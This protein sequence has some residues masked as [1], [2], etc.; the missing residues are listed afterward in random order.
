MFDSHSHYSLADSRVLSPAQIISRYD[1]YN[2]IGAV[3]SSTP[4]SKAELLYQHAPKRIIPFLSLYKTKANKP[5]WMLDLNTLNDIEA[6][7]DAFPYQGIGEF[8]IFK[9]DTYSPVLKRIIQI[10]DERSL[11]LQIHGDAE[12]VDRI[13]EISPNVQ[14]IW[15]HLGT[16]PTPDFLASLLKRHPQNLYIDTSVRDG[17]FFDDRGRLN[18]EWES[19]F[20]Q[21][22][23]RLLAA[24]DTYSTLR[25]LTVGHTLSKMRRWL[26]QLPPDVAH[27]IAYQNALKL[28]DRPDLTP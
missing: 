19:F 25:W 5:N 21:H 27:K 24:V 11:M 23:D 9:Q 22:Q 20:T 16:K 13:F 18:P 17:E 8:H 15:A 3:I 6:Q 12:I 4:T 1:K 28:F 10:A 7:L 26:T 2:V 14:V